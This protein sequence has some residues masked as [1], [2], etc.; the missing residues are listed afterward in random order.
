MYNS[1]NNP[2]LKGYVSSQER[3]Q[4]RERERKSRSQIAQ[5]AARDTFMEQ[6]SGAEFAEP[7]KKRQNPQITAILGEFD[8]L[9]PIMR[10]E[11][12][13]ASLVGADVMPCTP[14]P[15][16]QD[17]DHLFEAPAPAPSRAAMR[18]PPPPPPPAPERRPARV[19]LLPP[20]PPPPPPAPAPAPAPAAH[21]SGRAPR[22]P[23]RS[24]KVSA[25]AEGVCRGW[26]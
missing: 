3:D 17:H 10:S 20:P 23:A 12:A 7:I 5:Q 21:H 13:S 8:R 11:H 25:A 22:P 15:V 19:P 16:H 24:E 6:A 1:A 4:M 18:A 14:A 26:Y 9:A 2:M